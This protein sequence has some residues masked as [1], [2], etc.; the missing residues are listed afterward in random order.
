MTGPRTALRRGLWFI[1][2][3]IAGVATL[4]LIALLIRMALGL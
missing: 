2:L 3:W 1:L 4:G